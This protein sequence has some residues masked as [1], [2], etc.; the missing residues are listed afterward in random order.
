MSVWLGRE[1]KG[2]GENPSEQKTHLISHKL[3][4]FLDKA[5]LQEQCSFH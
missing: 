1:G 5:I 2:L 4:F 3:S